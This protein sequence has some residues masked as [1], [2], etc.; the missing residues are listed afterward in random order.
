MKPK[1]QFLAV[2]HLLNM[3]LSLPKNRAVGRQWLKE[4]KLNRDNY[5]VDQ[6][7]TPLHAIAAS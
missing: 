5:A 2:A 3:R 7:R 1:A 4:P 6:T